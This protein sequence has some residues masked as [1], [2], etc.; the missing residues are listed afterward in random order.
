MQDSCYEQSDVGFQSVA[1]SVAGELVAPEGASHEGQFLLGSR[2]VRA[3]RATCLLR[4]SLRRAGRMLERVHAANVQ[5]P[6]TLIVCPVWILGRR[7]C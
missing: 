7:A 5:G 2:V 6:A 3:G 4:T 1:E